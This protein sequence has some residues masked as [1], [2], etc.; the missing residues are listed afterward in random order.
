MRI[1]LE[2]D[3]LLEI[4]LPDG[5]VVSIDGAGNVSP[6]AEKFLDPKPFQEFSK[7]NTRTS[8]TG[9]TIGSKVRIGK[10]SIEYEVLQITKTGKVYLWNNKARKT[11]WTDLDKLV[12]I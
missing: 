8:A 7:S 5:E 9:V 1:K 11:K 6:V 4:E 10:G 2:I 3:D 12:K